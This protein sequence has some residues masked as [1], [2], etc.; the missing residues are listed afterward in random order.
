[1]LRADRDQ[2]A[3]RVAQDIPAGSYV[4]LGIGMP[5]LVSNFLKPEDEIILH[6]ENGLLGMGPVVEG[7]EIDWDLTNASK[8]P[9]RSITGAAFFDSLVSF[10]MMRGGRMDMCVLGGFQVA[11][12]GDLA[13]WTLGKK[14]DVPAVGGAMDLAVGAKKVFVMMTHNAKDGSPKIVE[15]CT[16]PLTGANIV[17]RIY[18]DLAVIDV[19]PDGMHVIDKMVEIS[20]EELQ[21][22]TGVKLIFS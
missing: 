9:V 4:N 14:G 6:S 18:T 15:K 21:A 16:L 10:S 20:D 1:M 11:A 7:D 2:I 17:E 5:T 3:A 12:N 22:Q 19:R 13:N 8:V